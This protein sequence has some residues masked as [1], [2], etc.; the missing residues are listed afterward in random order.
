LTMQNVKEARSYDHST[1]NEILA[2][3]SR[4]KGKGKKTGLHEVEWK[5]A[6]KQKGRGSLCTKHRKFEKKGKKNHGSAL[7]GRMAKEAKGTWNRRATGGTFH[8]KDL[9]L[10]KN[11]QRRPPVP[12]K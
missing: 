5:E 2:V 4:P 7:K 9:I 8:G 10:R 12:R 6:V 11:S 1:K 3:E